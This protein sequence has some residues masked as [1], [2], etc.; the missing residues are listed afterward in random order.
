MG[1]VC[2]SEGTRLE[3]KLLPSGRICCSQ[4]RAESRI[5]PHHMNAADHVLV[6]ANVLFLEQAP[7]QVGERHDCIP[8][9]G[10]CLAPP[11][12]LRT[13]RDAISGHSKIEAPLLLLLVV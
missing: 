6:G 12:K 5:N 3:L 9:Q 13:E 8:M 7:A 11:D 10:L 4:I 2:S 1:T